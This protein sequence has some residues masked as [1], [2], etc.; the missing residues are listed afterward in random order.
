MIEIE[1]LQQLVAIPSM[2]GEEQAAADFLSAAMSSFG[3]SASLDE[4]GNAVGIREQA[5]ENGHILQEIVLLGHI[6][7]VPGVI[8]VRIED[9][10]LFGRGTV[11]AKGPLAAFVV[12]AAQA[13]LP[14]GTRVVVVGAV[15]EESATSKGA[16]FAASQY[17]PGLCIIGEP[18]GWDGVTLGYKGRVLLDYSLRQPRGH[19]AGSQTGV[20]DTAVAW[21]NDVTKMIAEFNQGKDKLFDQ[22][23]PSLRTIQSGSDGLTNWV[24]VTAGIR[25][26]PDF[27]IDQLT[28]AVT[29]LAREATL[30]V[31]AHEPA[32]QSTRVSPLAR[33]FNRV[34]RQ[35][36]VRPRFKLK[37][38]TS[39]MNV[40]GP[41][42]NCPIVAY[43][44]GDSSLDHTPQEHVVLEEYL[45]AIDILKAVL[46][47]SKT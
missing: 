14:Q 39:D 22:L 6:D 31:Y 29:K 38:G 5:D 36:G 2:S 11:D 45:Q 26:P 15:E 8:P 17:D 28:E 35:A 24:T 37:T 25:L 10:V 40:V 21:W 44:P 34:L 33:T 13:E 16:R 19:T 4:A 9:G 30:K 20:A 1:L 3:L 46:A 43:G 7:T 42:W 18:S 12:A 27:D 32:L 23:L 41:I 47:Q